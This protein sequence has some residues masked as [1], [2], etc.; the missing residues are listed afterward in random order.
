[1]TAEWKP[2][3]SDPC[4]MTRE[5]GWAIGK[6]PGP[7]FVPAN[8]EMVYLLFKTKMTATGGK[9]TSIIDRRVARFDDPAGRAAAVA[10]LK[11][12]AER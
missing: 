4:L 8:G 10:E 11:L 9:S 12:R 3:K 6:S 2:S 7:G 1:M 5:G